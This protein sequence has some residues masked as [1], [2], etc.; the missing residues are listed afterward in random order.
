M[1]NAIEPTV[2]SPTQAQFFM[3]VTFSSRTHTKNLKLVVRLL[4][5]ILN[6]GSEVFYQAILTAGSSALH[7][8]DGMSF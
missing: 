8:S 2:Q 6:I 3:A 7:P 5:C 1:N 4:K